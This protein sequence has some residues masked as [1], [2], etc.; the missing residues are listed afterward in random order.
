MP[1]VSQLAFYDIG[2]TAWIN[3]AEKPETSQD[4][5]YVTYEDSLV[6]K[7]Q[8]LAAEKERIQ[9]KEVQSVV[10]NQLEST[11]DLFLYSPP[12]SPSPF[13][14]SSATMETITKCY[15]GG[16]AVQRSFVRDI[17][18]VYQKM[19]R[20][21]REHQMNGFG[22]WE[23]VGLIGGIL[24]G[25][26]R[27][28]HAAFLDTWNFEDVDN[29][30]YQAAVDAERRRTIWREYRRDREAYMRLRAA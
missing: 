8:N 6:E 17:K 22:E 18:A 23:Y 12:L 21:P 13:S 14:A 1:Y 5:H 25:E 7:L 15:G 4:S 24:L 26:A 2:L 27:D 19:L 20:D 30:N 9:D 16:G 28:V 3:T 29:T 11:I 10:T